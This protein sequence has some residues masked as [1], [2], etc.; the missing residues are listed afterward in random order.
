M[1]PRSLAA[2]VVA[3]VIAVATAAWAVATQAP[4]T[5]EERSGERFLPALARAANEVG[6]IT[7]TAGGATY[8]LQ[9]T[10][11]GWVLAD[12]G[13]Y[14]VRLDVVRELVG[15]LARLTVLEGKT[16]RV[17]RLARLDLQDP[18]GAEAKGRG[19]RLERAD[20]S[21][22]ADI[23]LGRADYTAS[24]TGGLYIREAGSTKAWLVEGKAPLPAEAVAWTDRQIL[25]IPAQQVA[26]VTIEG[27]QA[28]GIALVRGPEGKPRLADGSAVNESEADRLFAL[29]ERLSIDDVRPAGQPADAT[30]R[31]AVLETAEGVRLRLTPAGSDGEGWVTVAAEAS[32]PAGQDAAAAIAKRTSGFAFRLPRW[33]ADLLMTTPEKLNLPNS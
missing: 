9:R 15:G 12:K 29:V 18:T 6:R 20:G 1:T 31:G 24:G 27:G 21:V 26:R 5:P 2:L 10:P 14:P 33:K 22:V 28:A 17:D 8:T 32:E 25:D 7:V 4:N 19:V 23:V 30:V 3:T 16:D 13:N 11:E